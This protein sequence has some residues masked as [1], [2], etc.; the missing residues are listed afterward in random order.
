MSVILAVLKFIGILLLV[1]IGIAVF[2]CAAVVFVPV[3]YAAKITTEDSLQYGFS[4]SWLLLPVS[5]ERDLRNPGFVCM[6]LAWMCRNY[7]SGFGKTRPIKKFMW[8]RAVSIW[9]MTFTKKRKKRR[10]Q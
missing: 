9:S 4:A 6:Y 5:L 2:I 7:P 10:S 8:K 3:R 1:L